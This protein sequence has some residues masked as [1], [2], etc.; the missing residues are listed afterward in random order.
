ML[1]EHK[2]SRLVTKASAHRLI[3]TEMQ[4]FLQKMSCKAV[5]CLYYCLEFESKSYTTAAN[6]DVIAVCCAQHL[7]CGR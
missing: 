5:D 6:A 7:V 2:N 1:L 3:Q 4:H